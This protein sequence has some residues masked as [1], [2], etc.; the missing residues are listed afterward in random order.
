MRNL[1]ETIKKNKVFVAIATI[2]LG[3][4]GSGV[5][6]YIIEPSMLYFRDVILNIA[7]LGMELYKNVLY[8]ES[9][10]GFTESSSI[11][12]ISEFNLL[13]VSALILI[14]LWFSS[15]F[16][17]IKESTKEQIKTLEDLDNRLNNP[18]EEKIKQKEEIKK[19][20]ALLRE[21]IQN[22][23][24]RTGSIL[25][26]SLIILATFMGTSKIINAASTTY[27]NSA[28][29]HYKQ[30]LSMAKPYL[31]VNEALIIDSSF[32]RIEKKEDYQDVIGE[33]YKTLKNHDIKYTAF[34]VW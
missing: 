19:D 8:S 10:K 22:F 20:I 4:I 18:E 21:E 15:K 13:Y 7:T 25:I 14:C 9:A 6:K 17:D 34:D 27:I 5:W 31:E 32:S 3:A 26:I 30:H 11:K 2:T 1:F 12:L 28:V 29:S 16:K 24:T 23:N 33:I